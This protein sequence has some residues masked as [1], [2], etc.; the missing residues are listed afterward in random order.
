MKSRRLERLVRE[1]KVEKS[2]IPDPFYTKNRV[3]LSP[4][5][6]SNVIMENVGLG[7]YALLYN[8]DPINAAEQ[9]ELEAAGQ[10]D[11]HSPAFEKAAL[12]KL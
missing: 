6:H 8:P 7:K 10:L 3:H 5:V 2:K 12:E 11:P 1:G 4:W 9:A